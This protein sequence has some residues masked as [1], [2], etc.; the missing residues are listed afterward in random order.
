MAVI[1][2]ILNV[3]NDCFYIGS[4]VNEKRRRWEHWTAL[5]KGVHHCKKLQ[6]AWG[7]FGEDAFEL[8]ILEEVAVEKRL[9]IEDLYLQQHAKKEY[10]YNTM[11]S[12][13]GCAEDVSIREQIGRSLKKYYINN[14]HPRQGT[15]HS[16]K[17]KDK[18]SSSRT[19]KS[20]GEAHYRY[21]QVVSEEVRKKIGDT[22]RGV[23]KAPRTFSAEGLLKAQENMRRN[24]HKNMPANFT[25]VHAKFTEEVQQRYNFEKAV[26]TGALARIEGVICH[27]HG[28]FSQY[29]AQF[30]KGRG[31][32]DC[33]V[34]QRAQSKSAQMKKAWAD[35]AYRTS[36]I[37]QQN[38]GRSLK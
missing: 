6:E 3:V 38:K 12:T 22:Q 34:E 21:G 31:C 23:T 2:K 17:T 18:I 37:A 8:V 7:V 10:C 5:K 26:Y 33:G 4:A 29:A 20:A 24:A 14:A 28:V 15:Q 16:E 13:K 30:R 11:S 27:T 9:Q 32:P 35:E 19:G 1:Y 36:T 25:E